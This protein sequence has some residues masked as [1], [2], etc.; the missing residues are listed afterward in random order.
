MVEKAAYEKLEQRVKGLELKLAEREKELN[1]LYGLSEVVEQ[2]GISLNE[3]MEKVP[4][5]LSASWQYPQITCARIFM[6]DQKFTTENFRATKWRQAADIMVNG[7]KEGNIEIYYLEQRPELDE[8]P[9]SKEE[10]HLIDA[11]AER[12]GRIIERKHL[13]R[14]ARRQWEQF[15]SIIDNFADLLYISDPRTYEVLLVNKSL[16]KA[17]GKNPVGGLCYREFQGRSKQCEFCTNGII[18][19]DRKPYVWEHHNPLL[20]KDLLLTDQIIRWPDG[21]KVRYEIGIDI[22]ERKHMEKELRERN[23]LLEK[24]FSTTHLLIAYLDKEFNFLRVNRAYAAADGL[25]ETFFTG[26]NH[27]DLYP[28]PENAA[29]FRRVVETGESYTAVAKAFEYPGHPERGTSYWD[30]T[31]HPVKDAEG[32]VEGLLLCLIDVTE[33][34]KMEIELRETKT[35]LERT[36]FSLADAVFVVDPDTRTITTCNP[37][38]ENIFGYS[39]KE[40]VGKNTEFLHANRELYEEFGR[41]LFPELDEKGVFRTEYRMRRRDGSIFY[42]E[43]TVTEMLDDSGKRTGFVSVVSDITARRQAE[44]DRSR[45]MAAIEHTVEGIIITSVDGIIEYLNPAFENITGYRH[46]DMIGRDADAYLAGRHD[47]TFHKPLHETMISGAPW[48]GQLTR[49]RGEDGDPYDVELTVT[50]VYDLSGAVVHYVSVERDVTREVKLERDLRQSQKMEALGTLAGGIAHDFNNILMPITLNTEMALRSSGEPDKTSENLR[51]VLEAAQRGRELVKQ[52]ITFSRRKE[53]KRAL[54]R[55]APVIKE[56]L[57]LLR[58]SLPATIE[59]RENIDDEASN[60]VLA[61]PTQIHQVLMNLC[62]NAAYAMRK[63]GGALE[64]SLKSVEVDQTSASLHADLNPGTYCRLT[65]SDTGEGMDRDTMEHIF[66]PFFT[67]KER[68]EGTGM[69]LAVVHGIVKNHGG[70]MT[71]YSETGMGSTFNIF[72]PRMEGG[73]HREAVSTADIPTGTERILLVDDEEPV[74]GSEQT[75]LESLGYTVTAFARSDEALKLFH[76]QPKEFDLIIADQTMPIMTGSELSRKLM[77][78]KPDIP[79]ILCT[80]FS[81]AVDED[82][83]KADGI[84]EFIMK[85]FTTKEMAETIRRVLDA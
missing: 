47:E 19:K 26:R 55:I 32:A 43:N 8:G 60:V 15:A 85:P 40:V 41:R 10:R 49:K 67:T 73:L 46:H 71:V 48:S 2:H 75:M 35:F 61:D 51:Y 84:R 65:V 56:A 4:P 82:K 24:I 83:V 77:Q 52:I 33:R 22:T 54:V 37:A 34:K 14:E 80:G 21:R 30:W 53:Q 79:I 9:F 23:E 70:A 59:L 6:G 7:K 76:G 27:F 57:K 78:I 68:T 63:R 16:E 58:S 25:D 45:L 36:L 66:E 39:P 81:E 62:T 50:P 13:E 42:T 38:V 1:A 72:F 18:L 11:F 44:E 29:I 20:D 3:I 17:L 28:H 12:V 31:I 69:G 74:L 5:L 64:V